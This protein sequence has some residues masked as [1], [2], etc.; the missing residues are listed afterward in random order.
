MC[1]AIRNTFGLRLIAVAA[2]ACCLLFSG[3]TNSGAGS[4]A[5]LNPATLTLDEQ[6]AVRLAGTV[7]PAEWGQPEGVSP[8]NKP[9]EYLV[10]YATSA[11]ELDLLGMRSVIVNVRQGTAQGVPRE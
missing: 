2:A 6:Q 7:A 4:P 1:P 5:A 3:C 8:G 11:E 9:G 10:T